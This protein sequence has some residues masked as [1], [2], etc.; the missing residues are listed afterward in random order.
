MFIYHRFNQSRKF[1]NHLVGGLHSRLLW[2]LYS[3][4]VYT[5]PFSGSYLSLMI[6]Y[7]WYFRRFWTIK[8]LGVL[9]IIVEQKYSCV[10]VFKYLYIVFFFSIKTRTNLSIDWMFLFRK[11]STHFSTEKLTR[12][13]FLFSC[14]IT[15]Q[16][17]IQFFEL[18]IHIYLI[19][20]L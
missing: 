15:N 19:D 7:Q 13:F 16:R 18:N 6:I 14:F 4:R 17:R 8:N 9:R 2:Y 11:K 3:H 1:F 10:I 20:R 5:L 12:G